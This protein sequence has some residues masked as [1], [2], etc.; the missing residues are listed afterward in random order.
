MQLESCSLSYFALCHVLRCQVG[1][2]GFI[3][4]ETQND[5]IVIDIIVCPFSTYRLTFSQSCLLFW[6]NCYLFVFCSTKHH[7]WSHWR[8]CFLGLEDRHSQK[9]RNHKM[10]NL[11]CI[12]Y[13]WY[14]TEEQK[15]LCYPWQ[16]W[17]FMN[18]YNTYTC[19][20]MMS[21]YIDVINYLL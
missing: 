9:L 19:K 6:D 7:W 16:Y 17:G 11:S 12:W 4:P 18:F 3:V 14:K 8:R 20:S 5:C 2:V 10:V 15:Q 13:H 1:N 21:W